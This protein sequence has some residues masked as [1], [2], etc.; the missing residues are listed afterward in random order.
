MSDAKDCPKCGL[1]NP[2]A[3]QRCDCGYD[4]TRHRPGP[5]SFGVSMV[6]KFCPG[7]SADRY[8]QVKPKKFVAFTKD[9]VCLECGTRYTPPT[10]WW[11]AIVFL[12]AG[13]LLSG[14]GLFSLITR[15]STGNLLHI[16][17]MACEG[18]LGFLGLLPIGQGVRA[19]VFPGKV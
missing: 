17:A 12:L 9:R 5:N 2:P 1:V 13:L 10:P 11:G 19:L 14:F 4:F 18:F 7:C 3:A 15:L 16:P 8:K 6:S